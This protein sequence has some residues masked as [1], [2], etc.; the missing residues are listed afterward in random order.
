M[1]ETLLS[2]ITKML[3]FVFRGCV[4]SHVGKHFDEQALPEYYFRQFFFFFFPPWNVAGVANVQTMPSFFSFREAAR[5]I[6]WT[7]CYVLEG[8]QP[9]ET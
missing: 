8:V 5:F 2:S 6:K 1:R 7:F 4:Y 9:A 3:S